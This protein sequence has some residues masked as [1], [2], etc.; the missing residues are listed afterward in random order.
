MNKFLIKAFLLSLM[1][2]GLPLMGIIFSGRAVS[3]YLEFPPATRYV[4]HAPFSLI[5][6]LE[7]GTLVFFLVLPFVVRLFKHS[8]KDNGRVIKRAFPWWGYVGILSGSVFWVLAWTR[9]EWFSLFQHH[10]F[11]PLWMCYILVINGASYAR[12]KSCIMLKDPLY[13]LLLFPVSSVFWWFFEFLNRFVQNWYYVEV[14]QFSPVEYIIFAS[15]SFST[16]LPAVL[17][18]AEFLSTFPSFFRI[19]SGCKIN[20]VFK[21]K[22]I[23]ILLFISSASGLSLIGIFPNQLFSLLWISPLIIIVSL[24]VFTEEQHIFSAPLLGD[25]SVIVISSLAALICGFFWEM[26]NYYSLAKWIYSVPYV[27]RFSLFEMPLLGFAGYLPFGLECA[28]IGSIFW[29]RLN[30]VESTRSK[31]FIFF[32]PLLK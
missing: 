8:L 25:W 23:W 19:F 7:T 20:M 4:R 16:V 30:R 24:Q 17:S 27:H 29:K 22:K 31:V 10:T 5:V 3:L 13:F 2:L 6:F 26:W 9:F 28:V 21:S 14:Y 18:T 32:Q 15:L 12:S 1:I 11:T